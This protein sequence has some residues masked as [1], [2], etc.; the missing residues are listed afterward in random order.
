MEITPLN[1]D[2]LLQKLSKAGIRFILIDNIS[3]NPNEIIIICNCPF[4]V[5][6]RILKTNNDIIIDNKRARILRIFSCHALSVTP[7]TDNLSS[8]LQKAN[9][10]CTQQ[11]EYELSIALLLIIA[12]F[13]ENEN[14]LYTHLVYNI[15]PTLSNDSQIH[16]IF[17]D[18]GNDGFTSNKPLPIDFSH[19]KGLINRYNRLFSYILPNRIL[20]RH[21]RYHSKHTKDKYIALL[22]ETGAVSP[23]FQ[24]LNYR[25]ASAG[26][27]IK[28]S[29]TFLKGNELAEYAGI[30]NEIKIRKSLNE[31]NTRTS[32]FI[33][34]KDYSE[35]NKWIKYPFMHYPD[36]HAFAQNN[37]LSA[38]HLD[39]LG[40]FLVNLIDELQGQHLNHNDLKPNNIMVL[41]NNDNDEIDFLL[42]DF[43][44]AS[45]KGSNPWA[46]H[47]IWGHYFSKRVCGKYRY[48]DC[49][50]DDAASAFL[51]YIECGGDSSDQYAHALIN[52]IGRQYI[53]CK[54]NQWFYI[55]HEEY[56]V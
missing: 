35:E 24:I 55:N 34:V 28:D 39:K 16:K 15:L 29:D 9:P 32:N 8:L 36:L 6:K 49:I 41:T 51:S 21:S 20:S 27:F 52:R 33:S 10:S 42:T 53:Y 17:K 40:K 37:K 25:G 47:Q 43:G 11:P 22:I 2:E 30:P 48:D 13:H 18:V 26:V 3:L 4:Y 45:Y 46:N 1:K 31:L 38:K 44:C 12:Y 5:K 19:R 14:W 56:E 50:I 54:H 23:Q 7:Y